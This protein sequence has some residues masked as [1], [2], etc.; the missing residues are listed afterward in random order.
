MT[1]E[2]II[3]YNKLRKA[4][5]SLF[6]NLSAK[7]SEPLEDTHLKDKSNMEKL[8]YVQSQTKMFFKLFAMKRK[9]IYEIMD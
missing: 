8:E 9:N 7:H 3:H 6:L 1:I 2:A 5:Q 4:V